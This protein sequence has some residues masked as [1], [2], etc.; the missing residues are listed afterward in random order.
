MKYGTL[1]SLSWPDTKVIKEGKWYDVPMKWIGAIKNDK[2]AAGHAAM[3]LVADNEMEVHYFDYGRYHTP[4]QHGRVRDKHTDPDVTITTKAIFNEGVITNMEEILMEISELK[5]T[6]GD[7]KTEAS[8]VKHIRF[9]RAYEKA[10]QMQNQEA[11]PY[12]PFAIRGSTCA[13]FVTQVA[14]ESG[15][16][17]LTRLMIKLPYTFS[18]TPRTNLKVLNDLPYYYSVNQGSVCLRRS[19]FYMIKKLFNT[20]KYPEGIIMKSKLSYT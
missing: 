1:I 7:G 18:P 6:H 20:R 2:Y 19:K 11:I 16:H 8:I 15:V 5:A 4:L 10:K 14:N 17:W 3:L 9:D 12:G 13:K